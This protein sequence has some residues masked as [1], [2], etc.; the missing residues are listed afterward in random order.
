MWSSRISVCC[1]D[2]FNLSRKYN[3]EAFD[4][5]CSGKI[6]KKEEFNYRIRKT[7]QDYGLQLTEAELDEF[8]IRYRQY[9]NE[10][11]LMDGMEEVL[12]F[13]HSNEVTIAILTNG[14]HN[15]QQK[16]I[17]ALRVQSYIPVNRMFISEDLAV[18]KPNAK[19]FKEVERLLG[20]HEEFWY[21][22]DTFDID[23]VGAYNS[24]WK[25]IWFNHRRRVVN[26]S[27]TPNIEVQDAYG[28]L[29]AV[30]SILAT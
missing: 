4:L 29:E 14:N 2:L 3:K 19:A 24:G 20:A 13:L 30:K 9:Q 23:I 21:I 26:N 18:A 22:G 5:W 7:Y 28:L 17:D 15:D 12:E 25:S 1:E 6:D 8:Q 27:V 11:Y 10:I 16:K